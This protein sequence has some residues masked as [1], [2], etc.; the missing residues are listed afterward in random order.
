MFVDY[1]EG[2]VLQRYLLS[3][4]ETLIEDLVVGID[5]SKDQIECT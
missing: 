2:S 4:V 3:Q 5:G 1:D